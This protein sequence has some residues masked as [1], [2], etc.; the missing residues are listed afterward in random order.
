MIPKQE[1]IHI[2]THPDLK[3][4]AADFINSVGGKDFIRRVTLGVIKAETSFASNNWLK[5]GIAG[6]TTS[7]GPGHKPTDQISNITGYY[8]DKSYIVERKIK[9][10]TFNFV[11][12]PTSDADGNDF[13]PASAVA[14]YLVNKTVRRRLTSKTAK[15]ENPLKSLAD[16]IGIYVTGNAKARPDLH[17]K[18]IYNATGWRM[19]NS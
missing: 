8:V 10:A 3:D 11:A 18:T 15:D 4:A 19:R 5:H 1:S 9:G 17:A 2:K 6:I 13:I 16:T 14:S 7:A 12:F